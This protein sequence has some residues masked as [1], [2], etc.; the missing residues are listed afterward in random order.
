MEKI[1]AE[2]MYITWKPD[3]PLVLLTRP[4]ETIQK[5]ATQVGIPFSTAQLLDKG[6]QI[7]KNKRD[8]KIKLT[9]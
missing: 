5:M 7:I 9:A 6:I 4:I 3:D 8:F 2:V 1:E